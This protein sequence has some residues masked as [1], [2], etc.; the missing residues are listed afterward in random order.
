MSDDTPVS[1]RYPLLRTYKTVDGNDLGYNNVGRAS[2]E[3]LW[4]D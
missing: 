2:F 3:I 1:D 4:L